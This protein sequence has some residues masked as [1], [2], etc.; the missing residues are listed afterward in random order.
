MEAGAFVGDVAW[1]VQITT[2]LTL[3][4]GVRITGMAL[5]GW[6]PARR[7]SD[8]FRAQLARV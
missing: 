1:V 6:M 5:L 8:A 4:G 7:S 2:T 3:T